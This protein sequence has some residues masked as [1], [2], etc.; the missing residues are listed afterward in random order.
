[1]TRRGR[2]ALLAAALVAA[3]APRASAAELGFVHVEANVG[4]ASGGHFGL[5]VE[6]DVFH[7][8]AHGER[9]QLEREAWPQF[10]FRYGVLENRP[11]HVA[12]VALA[13]ADLRR[14]RDGFTEVHLAQRRA[15]DE[16]EDAGLDLALLEALA[17]QREGVP[18]RGA[19]LL[20][21]A[22]AG[23]P[24]G[25]ALRARVAELAG[26]GAVERELARAERALRE[27][28]A[29]GAA[30]GRREAL[31]LHAA[32]VALR[33]GH[34][35]DPLAAVALAE[36]PPLAVEERAGLETLARRLEDDVAALLRSPRPDR[37][38]TL[39]VAMARHRAARR[40]LATGSLV[41][42]D[43]HPDA[44]ERLDAREVARQREELA[45]I[46]DALRADV[47]A[48]RRA[49]AAVGSERAWHRLEVVAARHAEVA[50]GARGAASVRL[51]LG[52]LA[53]QRSRSLAPPADAPRLENGA[54]ALAA[55]RR[56]LRAQEARRDAEQRYDLFT[57]NCA[58][59]L[60][61]ILHAALGGSE[62]AAAALGGR[63]EP[64]EGLGF[65]PF[66]LFDQV[67]ERLDVRGVERMP[68]WRERAVA[69]LRARE[70]GDWVRLREASALT[71]RVYRPRDADG[72]FLF[73]TDRAP[74]PRPLAGALNLG[75]AVADAA[76]GVVTAPFDRGRRVVRAGRGALFSLPEL[77]F[78]NIRKGTFDAASLRRAAAAVPP[79][80]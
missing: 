34:G 24:D 54:A 32:L 10:R 30:R 70:A 19:G 31:A 21:P 9:I 49:V 68:A 16:L 43:P 58:T 74:A 6:D 67:V 78:V 45:A 28:F 80:P 52:P 72:S 33:D 23:D 25:L 79:G 56:A 14:V 71:S 26:V 41:L 22:R 59:E 40:S 69:A 13:E 7:L 50:R 42:V 63:I 55:A 38:Q 47:A 66:V 44:A 53:P 37:G 51:P 17:G 1:V 8:Q 4:G 35:L 73:F 2:R 77:V 27:P 18:I 46:A 20:D 15:L 65:V 62:R 11:L 61:R 60:V 3:G 64:G 76:L 12:R 39:F 29:P 75:F 5:R 36:D 48:A 57:A